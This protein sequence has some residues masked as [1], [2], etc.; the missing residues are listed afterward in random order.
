MSL[1]RDFLQLI[2]TQ[3]GALVYHLVTLFAIQLILGVAIGHWQRQR[4]E[5][6]TR[7]LTMAAGLFLAR[8]VL[9]LVA[10]L[11]R[12]GLA[13]VHVIL[14]P[15][16][17]F[18]HLTGVALT[19][20]AFLP[21]AQQFPRL[22]TVVL[23]ITGVIALGMYAVFATI[24]PGAEAAGFA[25]NSYWQERIWEFSTTPILALAFIASLVWRGGQWGWLA[26][27]L[28]LWLG[29]H[30]L[31]L[32]TPAAEANAPGWI[33]LADLAAL[34]LLAGLVYRRALVTVSPVATEGEKRERPKRPAGSLL[35]ILEAVQR[36]EARGSITST[37]EV[38]A[39]A[40]A[41][42]IDADMVAIGL[43]VPG[44]VDAIRIAA[45]HPTTSVMAENQEPTLFVSKHPLLARVLEN[46]RSEQVAGDRHDSEMTALYH[47]L[48]FDS[49]GPLVAQPLLLEDEAIGVLLVGNPISQRKWRTLDEQSLEAIA[50]TLASAIGGGEDAE[51]IRPPELEKAREEARRMAERAEELED[52][53]RQ[54]RQT[55]E[56]LAARLRLREE[57][58][59]KDQE[60]PA[61]LDVWEDE[62]R[63]LTVARDALRAQLSHWRQKAQKLMD[64][65]EQLEEQLRQQQKQ[66]GPAI[67]ESQDGR[68]AGI[69]VGDEAGRIIVA[70]QA[71]HRILG[72][73]R[74]EFVGTPLRSLF[75]DPLWQNTVARLLE[76][77][78]EPGDVT[79]VSLDL[80]EQ[81]VRAEVTRLPED[82]SWPGTLAAVFYLAE[83]S[84]VRSEMVAS[85]IQELRTP[86]TSITGY[87]DLLLGEKV[88]ILGESQRQ[89]LL[90]IEANIDRIEALLND[91][92]KA[93]D[94][95]AGQIEL[96]PEP[97]DVVAVLQEVLRSFSARLKEKGLTT[98]AELQDL[99]LVYADRDSLHQVMLNLVSN[100]VLAS[101]PETE[102]AVRAHFEERPDELEDLP[103]YL[104]V[105]VTDTGGGIAPADQRHVFQRFYGANN[106]RIDGLGETGVGLSVAKALIEANGGRIW[107]DSEMGVGSTFSFILPVSPAEGLQDSESAAEQSEALQ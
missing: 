83:G 80:G 32:A 61:G 87:T 11:D 96:A 69:L 1:L 42:T 28:A 74:A 9:M 91:L 4:D 98:R 71:I 31:Q 26:C 81:L 14:P 103:P 5:R 107:V 63:E 79:T 23:V 58:A 39:S 76:G 53:L 60:R 18:L 84:T 90:R 48:G 62:V 46:R 6:A 33:R 35:G 64:D 12:V 99:P 36:I 51:E 19:I 93:S 75:D 10:V 7:L 73:P 30:G 47:R 16:E 85:L 95:D 2:G 54:Q 106:P 72:T 38:A 43:S 57:E 104:L 82:E 105:S 17:R 67:G 52:K 3:P 22:S 97:V 88:G 100:A 27:L 65:K 66:P 68:F 86:M 15:L 8:A 24:W 94:V 34:P 77:M 44:P 45:L 92:V 55:T 59:S 78:D 101:K 29:G 13:S 25:Y 41:R 20:W 56:E 102:I 37:L 89:F 50:A 21:I 70:S 40:V 49:Q